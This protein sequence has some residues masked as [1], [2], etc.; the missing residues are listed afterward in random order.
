[1]YQWLRCNEEFEII[2]GETGP[3]FLASG[4]GSYAVEIRNGACR[5]TSDCIEL[6]I[7]SVE[8][9]QHAAQVKF[10]PNPV[11]DVLFLEIDNQSQPYHIA[12]ADMQ[13]KS[14][15]LQQQGNQ[16]KASFD[17]ST[18]AAGVYVMTIDIGE[19]RY[20]YRIIKV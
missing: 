11:M 8:D 12:I 3:T 17:I 20:F 2:E 1:M 5:D 7:T 10:Y 18:F 6:T 19:K 15:I 16:P 13:G 9:G 4:S 14:I